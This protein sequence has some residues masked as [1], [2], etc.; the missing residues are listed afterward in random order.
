MTQA[1]IVGVDLSPRMTEISRDRTVRMAD[2]TTGQVQVPVY[3]EVVTDD[4]VAYMKTLSSDSVRA[5]VASDVFIYIGALED[6]FRECARVLIPKEGLLV[7]TLELIVDDPK[8][9]NHGA[10][11][12]VKLLKSGRFG[13]SKDYVQNVAKTFGFALD[14]W[15]EDVLRTQGGNPVPG[16]VVVLRR[17]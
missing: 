10:T 4:G 1:Q 9:E 15:Q 7:F 5:V 2:S 16:A 8:D 3:N 11:G 13:H 6:S 14:L 17:M 12:G